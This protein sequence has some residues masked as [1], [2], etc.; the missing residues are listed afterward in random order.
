MF[1]NIGTLYIRS[2][3]IK[4]IDV[5]AKAL[6]TYS[7]QTLPV[8]VDIVQLVNEVNE[9]EKNGFGAARVASIS[10]PLKPTE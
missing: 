8:G 5:Q 2:G 4:E 3:D 10:E 6:T 1:I 7:G 9:A